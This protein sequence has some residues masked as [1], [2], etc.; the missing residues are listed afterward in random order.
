MSD[1]GDPMA[2]KYTG[3]WTLDREVQLQDMAWS[4]FCVLWKDT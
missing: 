1:R 4:M 3:H 2:C